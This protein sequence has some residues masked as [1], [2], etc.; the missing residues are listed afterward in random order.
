MSIVILY[1]TTTTT[2]KTVCV[3]DKRQ[4]TTRKTRHHHWCALSPTNTKQL[5]GTNKQQNHRRSKQ[6][7]IKTNIYQRQYFGSTTIQKQI[8][9]IYHNRIPKKQKNNNQILS[10]QIYYR[11]ILC[12]FCPSIK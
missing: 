6:K 12:V 11:K 10:Y 9:S 1:P 5:E 8:L 4:L 7:N 2:T 3:I